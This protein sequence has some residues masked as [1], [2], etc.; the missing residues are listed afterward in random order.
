MEYLFDF[1]EWFEEKGFEEKDS[2]FKIL[3]SLIPFFR[4]EAISLRRKPLCRYVSFRFNVFQLKIK[5][6]I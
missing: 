1:V 2:T 3:S 6:P 5:P 4:I